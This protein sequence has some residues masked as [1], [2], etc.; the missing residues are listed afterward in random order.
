HHRWP[1]HTSDVEVAAARVEKD[2]E[3][4]KAAAFYGDHRVKYEDMVAA[5]AEKF[6]VHQVGPN[7]WRRYAVSLKQLE[8]FLLPLYLDQIDKAKISEIVEHRRA[9]GVS[10]ATIRRDLTALSSVLEY[11]EVENNPALPRLKRLKERR[12]P[13]VL[14]EDAHILR[15]V[16]RAPGNLAAMAEAARRTG[17]PKGEL[18]TAERA[19][20][21][22]TRRQLTV[23]GK[24]NKSR[25]IDLDFGGAY[26]VLRKLPVRLGCKWLFWHGEGEPYRNLSSRFA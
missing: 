23:R 17:C 16:K 20:L 9:A 5:W 11:A 10:T 25:V 3:Q 7:T 14:P 21:D 1:L 18:V 12:D 2:I 24:G 4:R 13:I 19:K 15:M 6:I 8:P 22:H 26:E